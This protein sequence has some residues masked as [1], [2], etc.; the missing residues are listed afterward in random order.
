MYTNI[1]LI[2]YSCTIECNVTLTFLPSRGRV[3]SSTT[4]LPK[5]AVFLQL[6]LVYKKWQTW[7]CASSEPMPQEVLQTS[8]GF[9][10]SLPLPGEK[11]Q[12]GLM[13]DERSFGRELRCSSWDHPSPVYSS[14]HSHNQQS[15]LPKTQLN[16]GVRGSSA[17][18]SWTTQMICKF[19]KSNKSLLFETTDLG[20]FV[21]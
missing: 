1:L 2:F 20:W 5:L 7:C 6:S 15:C 16:A 17:K 12:N 13:E 4:P 18:A 19:M 9:L 8:I 14:E 10:E 11:A 21:M 3:C